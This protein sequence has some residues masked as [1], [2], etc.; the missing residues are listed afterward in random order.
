METGPEGSVSAGYA[1]I[2]G[3]GVGSMRGPFPWQ[4]VEAHRV[5]VPQPAGEPLGVHGL[6]QRETAECRPLAG[7]PLGA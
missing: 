4:Q 5:R 1:A 6:L 3:I 7:G 2:C